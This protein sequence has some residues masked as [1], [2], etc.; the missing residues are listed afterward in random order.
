MI[1]DIAENVIGERLFLLIQGNTPVQ[2]IHLL[3]NLEDTSI[4]PW[5][6]LKLNSEISVPGFTFTNSKFARFKDE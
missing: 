1:A 4:S 6:K 5:Y 3:K 2:S